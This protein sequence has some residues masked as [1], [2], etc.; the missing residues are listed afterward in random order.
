V[1]VFFTAASTSSGVIRT[2]VLVPTAPLAA[3]VRRMADALV[4]SGRSA[5]MKPSPSPKAK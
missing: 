4:L 3:T 2:V 5:M 1:G